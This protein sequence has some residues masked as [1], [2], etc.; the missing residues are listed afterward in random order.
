MNSARILE[1]TVA[2]RYQV[3]RRGATSAA[4][5]QATAP[6]TTAETGTGQLRRAPTRGDR[7]DREQPQGGG[8]EMPRRQAAR[9]PPARQPQHADERAGPQHRGVPEEDAAER[10]QPRRRPRMQGEVPE[11]DGRGID[12]A[13]Q[14][15]LEQDQ[16]RGQDD[17]AG[18]LGGDKRQ[19]VRLGRPAARSQRD[20]QADR[21]RDDR[22]RYGR[23]RDA[24]QQQPEG[25]PV[26]GHRGPWGDP[27]RDS[28]QGGPRGDHH[29][30]RQRQS[31][32]AAETI[33]RR[34]GCRA[35]VPRAAAR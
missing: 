26:P 16:E 4:A 23:R 21:R 8:L 31:P 34:T 22:R 19:P 35:P 33:A 9:Q 7:G 1:A 28:E 10:G 20:A 32:L 2:R 13:P 11:I 15:A 18:Q 6:R 17:P 3:T 24:A 30:D 14:D 12:A 5:T 25:A 29:Q 27:K